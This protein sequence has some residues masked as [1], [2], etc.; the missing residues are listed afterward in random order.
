MNR[1]QDLSYAPSGEEKPVSLAGQGNA[2]LW[3]GPDAVKR[4][5]QRL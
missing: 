4:E 1:T 5:W 2:T 3:L